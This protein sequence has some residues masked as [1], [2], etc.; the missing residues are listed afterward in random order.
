MSTHC[1][2]YSAACGRWRGHVTAICH[3]GAS[4]PLVCSQIVRAENDT[5]IFRDENFLL[6]GKPIRESVF[7]A[8]ISRQRVC[9]ACPNYGFENRPDRVTITRLR[10][11]NA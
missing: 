11:T 9:V 2:R 6:L 4:A 10:R 1:T 7:S 3:M 5:P 8:Q